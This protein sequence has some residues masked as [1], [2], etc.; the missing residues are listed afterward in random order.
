VSTE[1]TRISQ[2]RPIRRFTGVIPWQ[3]G[4]YS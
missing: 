3:R 1:M 2:R 4:P